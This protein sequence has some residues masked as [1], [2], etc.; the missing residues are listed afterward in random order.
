MFRKIAFAAVLAVPVPANAQ[1][2]DLMCSGTMDRGKTALMMPTGERE[3]YQDTVIVKING[4]EGRIKLPKKMG[5]SVADDDGYLSF[6]DIT[7]TEDEISGRA[8]ITFM[9]KPKVVI[10][11]RTGGILIRDAEDTYSGTCEKYDPGA[12]KKF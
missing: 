4:S 1:V 2:I 8:R 6:Q 7:M 9:E 3:R 11:R 5:G 10:N 12:A